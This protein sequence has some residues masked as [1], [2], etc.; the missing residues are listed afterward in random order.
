ME[1]EGGSAATELP[2]C[3]CGKPNA[4]PMSTTE[5]K[6]NLICDFEVMGDE[7]YMKI[8]VQGCNVSK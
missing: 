6:K 5:K 2:M 4:V 7:I 8:K 1:K 3:D